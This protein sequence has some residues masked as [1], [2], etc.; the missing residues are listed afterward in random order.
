MRFPPSGVTLRARSTFGASFSMDLSAAEQREAQHRVIGSDF[1][2]QHFICGKDK[3]IGET[4]IL[5]NMPAAVFFYFICG[6][7]PLYCAKQR[8]ELWHGQKMPQQISPRSCH[9]IFRSVHPPTC[10]H[11]YPCK[12]CAHYIASKLSFIQRHRFFYIYEDIKRMY[13]IPRDVWLARTCSHSREFLVKSLVLYRSE[14][15]AGSLPIFPAC[16]G[17]LRY[18]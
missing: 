3:Y 18:I 2:S 12:Q 15:V 16:L 6:S 17:S 14:T 7:S 8:L 4:L 10:I 13:Y 1:T 9:S 5:Y 11:T